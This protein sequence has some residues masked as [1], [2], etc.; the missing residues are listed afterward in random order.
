VPGIRSH[1]REY[2]GHAIAEMLAFVGLD[3]RARQ[4]FHIDVCTGPAM[5]CANAKVVF[6][7]SSE[8]GGGRC[9]QYL[10]A[11]RFSS[12][13]HHNGTSEIRVVFSALPVYFILIISFGEAS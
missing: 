10:G 5:W 12:G 1:A 2:K 11:W 13:E 8:Q 9:N 6:T 4:Q 7:I 3:R